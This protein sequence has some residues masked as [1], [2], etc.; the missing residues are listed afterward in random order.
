MNTTNRSRIESGE[1]NEASA[2]SAGSGDID[3]APLQ[4]GSL[5]LGVLARLLQKLSL[6]HLVKPVCFNT[7][8]FCA[9]SS[10]EKHSLFGSRFDKGRK[11]AVF[12]SFP[13][14]A[15]LS[16]DNL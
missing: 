6:P 2:G 3:Q 13:T 5:L 1:R 15:I 8:L 14:F 12:C 9:F 4:T 11:W 7:Q 16:P 10:G